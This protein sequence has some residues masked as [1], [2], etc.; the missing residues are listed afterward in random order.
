MS[1]EAD[2]ILI[3]PN[4]RAETYQGLDDLAAIEPPLWC[5]LITGYIWD[6]GYR[7]QIIDADAL[8][9]APAEIASLVQTANPLLVAIIAFGHQPSAST[10]QM[11]GAE[12]LLHALE[13]DRP[14]ILV[15]GHVSALPKETLQSTSLNHTATFACKGEGPTTIFELLQWLRLAR[16]HDELAQIP[17]L[18]WWDPHG[19]IV[20]NDPA[21]LL[22]P[23]VDLHGDV[24]DL[25]PMDIYRPHNWQVFG[26]DPAK[27]PYA[28]IYTSLGCPYKCSFC[29]INAPFDSNRYRMR[30]PD[31]VVEE[32][33]MLH[34]CYGV[35]T[36]KIIDEMFVLNDR[37]VNEICSRLIKSGL[38]REL[39]IWAYARVDTI[40]DQSQLVMMRAAGIKWLALGIESGSKHV[41]DGAT[42]KLK[43]DDIL[44]VVR[45]IQAAGVNVIGNFIFGLPDDT[46]ASMGETIDLAAVLNCEFANFYCAMPYP[47]S[48]LYQE[49]KKAGTLPTSWSGYS[50]H[51]YDCQPLPTEHLSPRQ[52]LRFRDN[53][54]QYYFHRPEY[55]EMIGK[56]FGDQAVM[57]ITDMLSHPIRRR[58][59][60]EQV[61]P[62]ETP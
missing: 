57:Q 40:R 59:L 44:G 38:G 20:V 26:S 22:D 45:S 29:C 15:G 7:V 41:R 18:V 58:L 24:W 51:S 27:E 16:P 37:H 9:L 11:A 36:F 23:S 33:N 28:S 13:E 43:N 25:L 34:G 54:F 17:G 46:Y 60:E 14:T 2:L 32:I 10:Q 3:N 62:L 30:S 55:L 5:R 52:V 50:Q 12:V 53:A 4:C 21:P 47:G 35:R 56:K 48:A 61:A 19:D 49:A 8:N 42:K 6:R 39:N 31:Q 1:R